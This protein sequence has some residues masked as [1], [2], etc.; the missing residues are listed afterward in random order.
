MNCIHVYGSGSTK[1]IVTGGKDGQIHVWGW[2]EEKGER[3]MRAS[4][5]E[6][7]RNIRA[8]TKLT[9][10]LWLSSPPPCSIK[11]APRFSLGAGIITS[12][13]HTID[14]AAF[15]AGSPGLH[16]PI[17]RS[18][19]FSGDMTKLVL[20]TQSSTIFEVTNFD[21]SKEKSESNS[22]PNPN[23]N[24]TFTLVSAGHNKG[25]LWGLSPHPNENK[26]AT[27]GDDK[28]L[29]IWSSAP[30]FTLLQSLL[31]PSK[32]RSVAYSSDGTLLAVGLGGASR[33]GEKKDPKEGG[34]QIYGT[35]ND[36]AAA[37]NLLHEARD[38]KQYI[39]DIKWAPDSKT[40]V[41]GSHDN[42]IY[43]Y[44]VLNHYKRTAKFN[45][46]N[47]SVTHL[48]ISSDGKFVQSN[49]TGYELLFSESHKGQQV[50]E[51]RASRE[52]VASEAKRAITKITNFLGA[53]WQRDEPPGR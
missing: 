47:S 34:F 44:S 36:N 38:S 43:M 13:V 3:T 2:E 5:D 53:D 40:L 16:S 45:K 12:I 26:F 7:T 28:T 11:Y 29:R 31:L 42:S 46:H 48:D 35:S 21:F 52:R 4:L 37:L 33:R 15:C 22:N 27:V 6:E 51:S 9:S 41:I 24:P 10:I 1:K 39:A 32:S 25:E 18:M 8:T 17:V 49:C 23:P 20:G 19:S 14:V 50:S 30:P